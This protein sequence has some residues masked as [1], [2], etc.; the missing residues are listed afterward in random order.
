M[1]WPD[2][3]QVWRW[4]SFVLLEETNDDDELFVGVGVVLF[5][6]AEGCDAEVD[7]VGPGREV[8]GVVV[9]VRVDGA[10]GVHDA[11]VEVRPVEKLER[12]LE[13]PCTSCSACIER[14]YKWIIQL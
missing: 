11:H 10:A 6:G 5:T 13:R 2:P 1:T 12:I 14:W 7:E 9:E 3:L 8:A 4:I